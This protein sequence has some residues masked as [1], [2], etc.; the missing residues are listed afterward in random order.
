MIET[1]RI[2]NGSVRRKLFI[3]ARRDLS[4][5]QQA[6]QACHALAELMRKWADDP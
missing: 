1:A 2:D 6:V 3:L 5:G 4:S